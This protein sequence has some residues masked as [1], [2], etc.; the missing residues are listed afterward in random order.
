VHAGTVTVNGQA[1]AVDPASTT[2][3]GLVTAFNNVADLTAA[4]DETTGKID[5]QSTKAGGAISFSDTSGVLSTLGI[6]SK[7]YNG[8]PASVKVVETQTGT[9]TTSNADTVAGDVSTAADGL[10]KAIASLGEVAAETPQLRPEVE[11]ALRDAINSLSSAGAQGLGLR[12]KGTDIRLGVDR[13]KLASSLVQ[14]HEEVEK[15]LDS[16]SA[17]IDGF[18][19]NRLPELSRREIARFQL[20]PTMATYAASQIPN[21]LRLLRPQKKAADA[22]KNQMLLQK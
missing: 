3:R 10:N 20:G 22:Y 6:F 19:A 17:H 14:T 11:N 7:T 9:T 21:T 15:A 5:I 13:T 12:G 2:I 1:I 8:S 16:F 18:A 4:L